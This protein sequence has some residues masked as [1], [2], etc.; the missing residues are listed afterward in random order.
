MAVG[1][2][3]E[4]AQEWDANGNMTAEIFLDGNGEKTLHPDGWAEHRMEYN[5]ERQR[6]SERWLGTDGAPALFRE[7][8][9]GIDR[10]YD[11]NGN[12]TRE[13]YYDAE[14]NIGAN[15][16]GIVTVERKYDGNKR[17]VWFR[18]LDAKGAPTEVRGVTEMAQE[19]D[20]DGN[21]TED[22]RF[23]YYWNG[24]NRMI[25]AE[26]KSAPSGRQPYVIAY[27][28]DHMGRN[29]IKDDAK[30]V[31]DDYNII[32]ENA[33]SSNATFNTW[34]LDLDGTMQG[35]GGVGGL[36]AV[37]KGAAA[38]LPAYDANGNVTEYV[39]VD[40][41]VAA[42]YAYSAFGKQMMAEDAIGFSHRFS[43]K[44]WCETMALVEYEFRKYLPRDGRWMGR[45][46]IESQIPYAFLFNSPYSYCEI[47]G[48]YGN[49]VAGPGGIN[50]GP[51]SPYEPKG[52]FT[53]PPPEDTSWAQNLPNCPC[54]IPIEPSGC[55]NPIG[56]G[57]GWSSPERTRH[58]GGSWEIRSMPNAAGAGQQCVYDAAGNLINKGSGAGTPDRYAPNGLFGTIK[59]IIIDVLPY[60]QNL[61]KYGP[62]AAEIF[63][64]MNHPVNPG[65]DSNGYPCPQNDGSDNPPLPCA[66]CN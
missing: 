14:G 25:R 46:L 44:P 42:H 60:Y 66:N 55:P 49:P 54:N 48:L 2:I 11:E 63:D 27:A 41:A 34:G 32:V 5:G 16:G 20:A 56:T 39:T 24:E 45:D 15:S 7:S 53:P 1:V 13:T 17:I 51:S 6:V 8:Y 30:F 58:K 10:R 37:E 40:G 23:R 4:M 64:H 22:A 35:A 12:V 19:W 3:T 62:N 57:E 36:L 28:Y 43:T 31:W 21:M 50:W 33:A 59:H 9:S 52:P 26:E 65:A 18:Y 47:V 29:V 61:Y 38:Y